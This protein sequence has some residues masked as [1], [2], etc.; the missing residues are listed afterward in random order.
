V[1]GCKS[2]KKDEVFRALTQAIAK[3]YTAHGH[4]V[5]HIHADA[6]SVLLH[7]SLSS[8]SWVLLLPSPHQPI[9]PIV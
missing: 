4:R 9:M 1:D 5:Q 6:E 7:S 3:T 2:K 8:A